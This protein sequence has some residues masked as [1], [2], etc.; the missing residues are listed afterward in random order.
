MKRSKQEQVGFNRA[1]L[2]IITPMGLEFKRTS[3]YVG[4]CMA[5]IYGVIKYPPKVGVGWL[6]KVS[7]MAGTIISQTFIPADN[8][9][10][11]ESISKNIMQNRSIAESSRDP[12]TQKRAEK[13]IED[14]EH[15]LTQIDQ[16]GEAVGYMTNLV[17]PISNDEKKFT[18]LCKRV[19]SAYSTI[20]CKIRPLPNLQKPAYKMLS[21][22]YAPQQEII[23][24][25][26]RLVPLS[27]FIGGFPF[28]S[29]G[30]NDGVGTWFAMDSTGGMIVLDLWKRGGDRTNSNIVILGHSGQGKS[31]TIKNII[32]SEYMMGT[33]ILAIDPEREY[34]DLCHNL[35]GDWINCGGSTGGMINPLQVKPAP[36]DDED[37]AEKL[38]ED[39]GKGM[40]DL[41]LHMKTL[42]IFFNLYIPTISDIQKALLKECLIEIYAKFD[43]VWET[44]VSK[45]S[46]EDFPILSDLYELIES[47]AQSKKNKTDYETLAALLKDVAKGSDSFLWNG[48]TTINTKSKVICLDTHDLQN[49][50]DRVKRTQYF[51]ILTWAWEQMSFDRTEKVLLICDEAYLMIDPN[52]PQSLVFL[53][54]VSKR[55]RKYEAGIAI[56]SHS[57]V[58][59]LDPSVRMY[60][61]P[62][63]DMPSYKII[64]GCDGKDLDDITQ[65]YNLTDNEYELVHSKKRGNAL[66]MIGS[67]RLHVWFL[68]PDYKMELIG[69]GG[70]R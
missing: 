67:K 58:D 20:R 29:S 40:G 64:M 52:V 39:D 69:R 1:I 57:L 36:R 62:L 59:F 55:A 35:G 46:T 43:I 3:L 27:T 26:Q 31:T 41:G 34:R 14:G 60:G 44:D 12:L 22:H 16:N 65:L 9:L 2:N 42:E 18:N 17:M 45:L 54:N 23:D 63:L 8:T 48:K 61:Q 68:V 21:P 56:I 4:E 33:K 28:A 70:G 37:E 15:I 47:K 5:K 32:L 11:V 25:T 30:Y 7:N 13:G 24:V 50:D 6:S 10:L 19:E 49:T 66:M 53:R 51:N 38:Y